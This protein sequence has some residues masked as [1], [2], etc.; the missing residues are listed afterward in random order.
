MNKQQEIMEEFEKWYRTSSDVGSKPTSDWWLNI[1]QTKYISKE[2]VEKLRKP[3][4]HLYPHSE[5][6]VVKDRTYTRFYNFAIDDVL[7]IKNNE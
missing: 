1:I 2:S 3:L 5:K 6:S 7:N 4:P